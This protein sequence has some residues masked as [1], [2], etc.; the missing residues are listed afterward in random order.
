MTID[1]TD[2]PTSTQDAATLI[3]QLRTTLWALEKLRSG[4]WKLDGSNDPRTLEEMSTAIFD[5]VEG[6]APRVD[7]IARALI[8]EFLE[9]G[10]SYGGL[11]RAMNTSRATA[12]SR[13]QKVIGKAPD[14]WEV[15]AVGEP[16]EEQE[17]IT[18]PDA[19]TEEARDESF[20]AALVSRWGQERVSGLLRPVP[21]VSRRHGGWK[22]E[23][24]DLFDPQTAVRV[25]IGLEQS[26]SRRR[27]E[28]VDLDDALLLFRTADRRWVVRDPK[29]S[30]PTQQMKFYEAR[31][32]EALEILNSLHESDSIAEFF[33]HENHR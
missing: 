19:V 33:P 5:A 21:L 23:P 25:W 27:S 14:V 24:G 16:D 3:D 2:Y 13:A 12:Q 17:R 1:A 9:A 7:G 10:G 18:A 30:T 15:W 8:R 29:I 31:D 6:L 28:P 11:A 22:V 20:A 32:A 26:D 4:Q